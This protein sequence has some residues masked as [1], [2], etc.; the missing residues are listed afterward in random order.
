MNPGRNELVEDPLSMGCALLLSAGAAVAF[1]LAY[2]FPSCSFL[3]FAFLWCLVQL[4]RIKTASAASYISFA[5]GMLLYA[6]QMN[7]FWSIFG[8]AAIALW[9]VLAFWLRMFV[10]VGRACR[11]EFGKIAA[12]ILIPFLWM[13]FEYFRSELYYLRFSWLNVGYAFSGNN[14]GP[15]GALGVYGIGFVLLAVASICAL[16]SWKKQLVTI[17]ALLAWFA[18][19]VDFLS[20]TRTT[21]REKLSGGVQVAGMQMEF[22]SEPQVALCLNKL[23]KKFP[24]AQLLLLS[25]YTFDGPVP[26][27]IKTWC[28]KNQ[29]YLVVGAKDPVSNSNYYDTAFV[30]APS[31]EIVFRQA[32]SVPIQFFKDGLPAKEQELWQSPWGKIGFCVCYDLSYSRVTDTLVHMGAQAIVVP[33]MDLVDWGRHQH[34]MHARVAPIRAEEYGLPIF[35]LA[36]SGISQ[37]VDAGGKTLA[38]APMPGEEAM[39][40]ATLQLPLHGNLPLDRFIV[41]FATVVTGLTIGALAC[42][43]ISRKLRPAI[44]PPQA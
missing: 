15:V 9:A 1:H 22:P 5:L 27:S 43:F 36:S 42:I 40:S 32:K 35:R 31:G 8:P 25:K 38:T 16:L 41:P 19:D 30:I 12:T 23:L 13:G 44:Q 6:P 18:L 39:L 29:R 37:F 34:E 4:T 28:K 10:V 17:A 11:V 14:F 3:M 2:I 24:D 33:T 26:E 7:F 20:P 21:P